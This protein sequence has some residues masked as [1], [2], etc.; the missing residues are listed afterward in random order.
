[1]I[2][3]TFVIKV[4]NR[5]F[6]VL[7]RVAQTPS[8]WH[9]PWK[10]LV[11]ACIWPIRR[12]AE[13]SPSSSVKTSSVLFRSLISGHRR[14]AP[15]WWDPRVVILISMPPG[16]SHC[17]GYP[18]PQWSH[19]PLLNRALRKAG[20]SSSRISTGTLCTPRVALP[21]AMSPSAVE[22]NLGGPA[23]ITTVLDTGVPTANVTSLCVRLKTFSKT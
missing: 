6:I 17:H 18:N 8:V 11:P 15:Y 13:T 14:P 23:G 3:K 21:I 16:T 20:S 10:K 5:R 2:M 4:T 7:N 22:M 19:R 1:M 12:C 9:M